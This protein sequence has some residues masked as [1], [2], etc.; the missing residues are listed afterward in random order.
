MRTKQKA[1]QEQKTLPSPET[2]YLAAR[3]EWNE[4]YGDFIAQANN[5]RLAAFGSI[6]IAFI[7]AIGLVLVSVQHKVVPYILETN[8]YGEITRVIRADA[9]GSPTEKQIKAALRQWITGARA[10]YADARADQQI[11]DTTYAMTLPDSPAYAKLAAYHRQ[12]NPYQR[13]Q[14]ET[15]TLAWHGAS[16][17]GGS[18]WQL[19]WTETVH[20]RAGKL[21]GEPITYVA[22]VTTTIATPTDEDTITKNPLG[23]YVQRFSWTQRID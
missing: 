21:I 17:I 11:I 10:V 23:I 9:A 22:P 4:R 5:W 18:T 3:R 2:P 19:E 12:N 8:S 20:S 15:V 16:L 6:G 14:K 7:L 1:S 13:A